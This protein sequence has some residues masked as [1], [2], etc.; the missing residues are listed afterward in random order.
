MGRWGTNKKRGTACCGSGA[1]RIANC[2]VIAEGGVESLG[3]SG[4]GITGEVVTL[5]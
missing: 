1:L 2:E 5:D 4:G 3:G